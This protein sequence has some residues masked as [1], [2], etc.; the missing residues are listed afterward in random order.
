MLQE[1]AQVAARALRR[2][3]RWMRA[4]EDGNVVEEEDVE[5]EEADAARLG[6]W[7]AGGSLAWRMERRMGHVGGLLTEKV[8]EDVC[9]LGRYACLHHLCV[10]VSLNV[11]AVVHRPGKLRG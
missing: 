10:N 2:A 1:E 5:A 6:G 3:K 8:R 9:G 4:R 7:E 11:S